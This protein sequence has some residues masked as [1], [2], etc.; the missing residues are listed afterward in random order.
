MKLEFKNATFPAFAW[1]TASG[2]VKMP[3]RTK[4]PA[5]NSDPSAVLNPFD[6]EAP[7]TIDAASDADTIANA[8]LIVIASFFSMLF[9]LL[10]G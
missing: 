2:M 3:T 1:I 9:M 10:G 6:C 8:K 4:F 7:H 5:P